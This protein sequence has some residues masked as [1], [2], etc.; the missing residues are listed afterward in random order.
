MN[1]NNL[2]ATTEGPSSAVGKRGSKSGKTG[3]GFGVPMIPEHY[4]NLR[5]QVCLQ[6]RMYHP[7]EPVAQ[8]VEHRTFNAVVA[9]SSPARLTIIFNKL[10]GKTSR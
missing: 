2:Q 5:L 1:E 8:L 10:E 3:D 4:A 7:Q 9:G 6:F